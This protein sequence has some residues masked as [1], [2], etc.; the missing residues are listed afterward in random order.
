MN[1]RAHWLSLFSAIAHLTIGLSELFRIGPRF[2]PPSWQVIYLILP[3]K[4]DWLYPALWALTGVVAIFGIR[5]PAAV[6]ISLRLSSALFLTW[7]IAG[8]PAMTLG[9]GGNIQGAM[10]NVFT[11][12]CALVLSY[13]ISLGVRGNQINAQVVRLAE[14]VHDADVQNASSG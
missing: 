6:R 10:A 7:G 12:G 4:L 11:A 1:A 14:K 2:L 3:D 5:W 13:Y 8:I 9:L